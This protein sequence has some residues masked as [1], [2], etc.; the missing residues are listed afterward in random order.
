MI[1]PAT[2][3]PGLLSVAIK[4]TLASTF[5]ALSS[6]TVNAEDAPAATPAPPDILLG[7][8]FN[9]VQT[10]KLFPDQKTFA[11]AVPNSDP[12]MILADYRMQ[13]NQSGFD[14]RHFV[15]VNFT[16][17]KDGEKYVPPAGQSLREHIDGLWPVLTRSTTDA[18]KWD[19]LLPL[20]EPYVVPGGRFREI[21]YW[22]SYFTMLG[23]A[24]SNHWDKV[25]DMV[26]NFAYEIDSW[27]HIPNGNRT[28][29][30]SR[31]QPPFFA[32][33]VELLAQHDGNDALK[34]YL[35]QMLKEYSYWMEGVET[36]QPGQQNKRIVKL[37]DGTILNRYWD[38]RDSPR[39]E[40][41][42]EDIATAKSNPN[43]P[44]TEIY[45][46][47]RSAA[48]S[49]WDFSS[50]W[51][52]NPN[53]LGTLRTTSIVPVD[54]NALM[55]KMEKMISL[56]S[57]AAGDDAKAAQYD[58]FANAR[59]KGI[60]KYLWNDKEGWYADYDLKSHKVRNQLT[61][62]ALFPLYVNA[63]AKDRASKVAT[64]TQA[65][66]LQ[67]G[68]LATTSVKSGQQWDAP[69]GWAPL[70]WVAAS[71]L[72]NYGQDTVAMDV[73]WRF[74]TNVQ[75]TYDREK[76]LVEKYDVSTT[77][78]GGGGGEYPLQ[79]GFGWTNG[80]TLKML[81]LICAKEKPCDNVPAS[82]P[83]PASTAPVESKKQTQPTP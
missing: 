47:L 10:A 38:E 26:A 83:T 51:M 67:P 30:L 75:H 63:A 80:V 82:R 33:M 34:K 31:S 13:K 72:Q 14:L 35:P 54:L 21:Y 1:T 71:G 78:T 23:L 68:G 61:A 29:Y 62:A 2:R 64:A 28:Y 56:A 27:G 50:R 5:F 25:S 19:S 46:D 11:D 76:K 59:Q 3:H 73:T 77:G 42:V 48:A 40:S 16:L 32:F 57:K 24:E 37:D 79:D 44:A 49:G 17:P 55:Y 12:L 18:E 15:E 9:D 7:P 36:L 39:P 4:L 20:P 8:L 6:F 81:D 74:L 52:D 58:G 22:D 60:E 66:L 53:Q 70:Q 69:N 45:R 43:R 41:W 65:H